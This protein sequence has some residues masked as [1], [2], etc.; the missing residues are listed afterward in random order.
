MCGCLPALNHGEVG[1]TQGIRNPQPRRWATAGYMSAVQDGIKN[2]IRDIALLIITFYDLDEL[3]KG[4]H[5]H[6]VKRV[7]IVA[8]IYVIF[9]FFNH[10]MRITHISVLW[11][12][13]VKIITH[14][15]V[16]IIAKSFKSYENIASLIRC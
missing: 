5:M 2:I 13:I 7:K 10:W 11:I 8:T 4:E 12:E 1:V 9:T 15:T 14:Q 3:I 16:C 6:I